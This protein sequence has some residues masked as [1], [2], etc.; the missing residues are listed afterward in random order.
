MLPHTLIIRIIQLYEWVTWPPG[1][2]LALT[3]RQPCVN[4]KCWPKL[5]YALIQQLMQADV[6]FFPRIHGSG[7]LGLDDKKFSLH[8]PK[9][10]DSASLEVLVCKGRVFLSGYHRSPIDLEIE[11]VS[12]KS[13]QLC[14]T[15]C[16]P[17][18]C[19]PPGSSVHG[20]LQTRIVEWVAISSSRG[21]SQTRD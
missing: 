16:D 14:P 5:A 21:S 6:S 3:R 10:M 8:F 13:L 20:I 1:T 18:D 17:I 11:T 4:L 15:L 2:W 7:N 9:S 12:A 19:R